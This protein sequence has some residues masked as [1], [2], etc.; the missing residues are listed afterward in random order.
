MA[1]QR[2]PRVAYDVLDGHAVL[3]H[4]D[5]VEML[6]LN[7]TGT[8]VWERLDGRLDAAA[9]AA[10]LDSQLDG[11]T[12]EELESD[13]AA[14]LASLLGEGLVVEEAFEA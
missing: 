9:L 3:V 13:I 11:V 10:E 6:T 1:F 8:L 14:F 5:A 12:A 2:S 7:R 4:P